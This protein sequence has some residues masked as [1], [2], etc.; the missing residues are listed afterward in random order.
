[1]TGCG[2][3]RNQHAFPSANMHGTLMLAPLRSEP[4]AGALR[5]RVAQPATEASVCA[6]GQPCGVSLIGVAGR[7]CSGRKFVSRQEGTHGTIRLGSPWSCLPNCRC[8]HC[9][10][11]PGCWLKK[12]S[13]A[14]V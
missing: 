11:L 6:H 14:Y 5:P 3:K 1:M 8:S 4:G 9:S 10:A 13:V 2:G 12:G 7:I